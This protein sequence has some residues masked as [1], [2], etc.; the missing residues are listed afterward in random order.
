MLGADIAPLC[1]NWMNRI[2][3]IVKWAKIRNTMGLSLSFTEVGVVLKPKDET[4]NCL[5][6]L[7]KHIY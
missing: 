5:A 7:K 2:S 1:Q 6:V 4:N 3:G